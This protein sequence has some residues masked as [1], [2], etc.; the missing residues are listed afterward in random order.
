M[1]GFIGNWLGIITGVVCAASIICAL[2]P[3][4]KDDAMI[5]KLYKILELC[6]LNIWKAK[7]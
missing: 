5:A 6:A 7:Q 3:T 1:L 2:T 4:P